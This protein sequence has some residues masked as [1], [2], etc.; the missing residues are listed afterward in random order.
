MLLI[1]FVPKRTFLHAAIVMEE[2]SYVGIVSFSMLNVWKSYS[3]LFLNSL[4]FF[5]VFMQ[6]HFRYFFFHSRYFFV[7]LGFFFPF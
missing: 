5:R 4:F 3:F 1:A 6:I 2:R 7:I